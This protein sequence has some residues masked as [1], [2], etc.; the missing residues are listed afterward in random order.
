[1]YKTSRLAATLYETTLSARK[2]PP[3]MMTVPYLGGRQQIHRTTHSAGLPPRYWTANLCEGC[4]LTNV[5]ITSEFSAGDPTNSRVSTVQGTLRHMGFKSRRRAR[6]P[7]LIA[8]Q[9]DFPTRGKKSPMNNGSRITTWRGFVMVQDNCKKGL[10]QKNTSGGSDRHLG[11][12]TSCYVILVTWPPCWIQVILTSDLNPG[13]S[14]PG[15]R[16]KDKASWIP[17][18][19][20]VTGMTEQEVG[21]LRWHPEPPEGFFWGIIGVA[22]VAERLASSS[23][24]KANRVFSGRVTPGFSHVGIVPDDATG[25]R[26]FSM[27]SSFRRLFIPALLHTHLTSPS[28]AL[29]TSMG[30]LPMMARLSKTGLNEFTITPLDSKRVYVPVDMAFPHKCGYTEFYSSG[31]PCKKGGVRKEAEKKGW[32][33]YQDTYNQFLGGGPPATLALVVAATRL[34]VVHP[35]RH[36]WRAHRGLL[37]L[38]SGDA[39]RSRACDRRSPLRPRRALPCFRQHAWLQ[40]SFTARSLRG[41]TI[42]GPA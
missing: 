42:T 40:R 13:H 16:L 35:Q 19:G 37:P 36:A 23:P 26:V 41:P 33:G 6:V 29:K 10:A 7:L 15:S 9:T 20:R 2:R 32:R 8:F 31:L 38:S 12:P 21:S 1:M 39:R 4:F 25:R 11:F 5:A 14:L 22:T 34:E 24:T 27:I 17:Y 28:S 30:R 18:G 3:Q